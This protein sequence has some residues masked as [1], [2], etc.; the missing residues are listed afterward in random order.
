MQSPKPT[1]ATGVPVTLSYIDSNNNT[2]VIGQTTTNI[3]GQ[4]SYVF[5]PN[6]EGPYTIIATFQGSNSYFSS[7]SQTPMTFMNAA[8]AAPAAATPVPSIADQYFIPMS[9]AIIVII[10][11]VGAVLALLLVRRRP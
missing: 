11:I 7:T 1:N 10:V 4:Y 2:F 6:I 3:N 9:I 5:T 8:T